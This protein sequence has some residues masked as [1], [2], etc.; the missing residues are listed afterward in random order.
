MTDGYMGKML[1][2][3]LSSKTITEEVLDAKMCRDYIGGYGIGARFFTAARNPASL[4]LAPKYPRFYR[5]PFT[6]TSV[7]TGARYTVV[8]K[9]PLTGG[10]GMPIPAVN[11]ALT[12]NFP[13]SMLFLYRCLA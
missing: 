4:P 11:L 5:R 1:F 8:A 6:G 3:D 13:V 12:S 7:P 9:S 10:W 2:V